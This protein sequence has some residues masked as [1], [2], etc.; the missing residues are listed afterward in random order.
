MFPFTVQSNLFKD[1]PDIT[2]KSVSL[3][4][5]SGLTFL[6]GPN[7]SGKTRILKGLKGQLPVQRGKTRFLSAGRIG[8]L[9][10][11]RSNHDGNTY[12]TEWGNVTRNANVGDKSSLEKRH[13]MESI[14]GDFLTLSTR[15]DIQ[16]KVAERLRKLFGRDLVMEWDAGHLKPKF[17]DLEAS[18][19]YPTV[20]EAS[21]LLHLTSILAALYDDEVSTLLL[22]EPEIS[23][24]P[25]LQSFLLREIQRVAGDPSE[26]GK[27]LIFIATHSTEMIE[28][29]KP[30]DL[31]NVIF[32]YGIYKDPVQISPEAGELKGRKVREL[33]A[34]LGQEHKL[35]FFCKKPVLIEGPSDRIIC[36]GLDRKLELYMEAAGSQ[37]L[38]VIGKGQMPVV[39]KLMRMIGK[40][41]VVLADADALADGL[42]LVAVFANE[43]SVIKAAN[44][45][46]HTDAM[47]FATSVYG[48]LCQLTEN[49]WQDIENEAVTHPY[50]VNRD[51]SKDESM[52][53][54]RATFATLMSLDDAEIQSLN[55]AEKW[56]AIR[57]RLTALLNFLEMAGC[58]ILRKG[59]IESYYQFSDKQTSGEKP[60]AAVEEVIG[61]TDYN[62]ASINE[63]YSDILRCLRYAADKKVIDETRALR[64]KVLA[65]A[66]PALADIENKNDAD[67]QAL[68]RRLLNDGASLFRLSKIQN[69][70]A[71]ELTIDIE[72][73]VLDVSCFPI[74]LRAGD[75][76]I[77]EVNKQMKL[78]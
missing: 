2:P 47:S 44:E 49:H 3:T 43:P 67:L 53:K 78:V 75:N 9:E 73:K 24:H 64:E 72:S 31:P 10:Q 61:F 32:C 14:N 69:G 23:L 19:S 66:S 16:I 17:T 25:Q 77:T 38:P 46:G 15:L 40:T 41:P 6:V 21:G 54:R 20:S 42:D 55:N 58:F 35:A 27:K 13:S 71:T 26:T 12:S 68:A 18:L 57:S 59:S 7:G 4:I 34:R 60:S 5:H 63:N 29:Q 76:P 8:L 22:D 36:A 65:L 52:V 70:G 37:F 62:E 56:G 28:V 11:Y 39:A 33:L 74:R 45:Q 1:I 30:A 51:S 50:W 48:E